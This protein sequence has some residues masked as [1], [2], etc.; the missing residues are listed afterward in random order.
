MFKM[1]Q[2]SADQRAE[3]AKSKADHCPDNCH[4]QADIT[5]EI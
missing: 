3:T 4:S 2:P 5:T 1:R